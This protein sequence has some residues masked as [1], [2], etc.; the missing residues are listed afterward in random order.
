MC[1]GVPGRL[2]HSRPG[3]KKNKKGAGKQIRLPDGEIRPLA[4]RHAIA[5]SPASRGPDSS[6]ARGTPECRALPEPRDA[7]QRSAHAAGKPGPVVDKKLLLEPAGAA[8]AVDK[9]PQARS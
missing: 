4:Q 5:T 2:H 6:L 3:K 9:I 8:V 1:R 7:Y